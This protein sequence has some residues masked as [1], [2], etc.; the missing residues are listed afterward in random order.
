MGLC[1]VFRFSFLF[2]S[3][4]MTPYWELLRKL[5]KVDALTLSSC[6]P[7]GKFVERI[8]TMTLS[9]QL[10][11][12]SSAHVSLFFLC[13]AQ[14]CPFS[15]CLPWNCPYRTRGVAR[16][17]I[18]YL[19]WLPTAHFWRWVSA[20][21]R[22]YYQHKPTS[23]PVV[24]NWRSG[25]SLCRGRKQVSLCSASLLRG[26]PDWH[27]SPCSLSSPSIQARMFPAPTPWKHKR[28]TKGQKCCSGRKDITGAGEECWLGNLASFPHSA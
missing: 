19:S 18:H 26:F 17:A 7:H 4:G 23:F 2:C 24:P 11:R 20:D 5:W 10:C 21:A 8:Y 3:P 27:R 9:P 16:A 22:R 6:A 15:P 1:Y 25:Y 12:L 13:E 14:S 28:Q